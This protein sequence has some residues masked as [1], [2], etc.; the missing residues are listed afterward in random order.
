ML[1][2][3]DALDDLSAWLLWSLAEPELHVRLWAPGEYDA[4]RLLA[5]GP[6]IETLDGPRVSYRIFERGTVPRMAR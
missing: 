4:R 5:V 3:L 6:V 2:V 1:A